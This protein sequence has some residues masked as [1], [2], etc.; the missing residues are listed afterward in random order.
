MTKNA[1]DAARRHG[2]TRAAI[3]VDAN[4]LTEWTANSLRHAM[5]R[6]V[7]VVL[8]L[9]CG[10]P[11]RPKHPFKH[12]FYYLLNIFVMRGPEER[13]VTLESLGLAGI[14]VHDFVAP[15]E[16]AWQRLPASVAEALARHGCEVVIKFGMGL[17]RDPDSAGVRHG[18]LSFHHGD[19]REYRGRPAGFYEI[20]H[21]RT[22]MGLMVQRLSEKL[23]GGRVMAFARSRVVLH[24]YRQTLAASRRNSESLLT[25]A[26][27][28]SVVGHALDIGSHGTN[29]RLP[30]NPR[31][32]AFLC[33]LG[34]RKVRRLFYGAFIEKQWAV[35]L[36]PASSAAL[37]SVAQLAPKDH[38]PSRGYVFFADSFLLPSGDVILEAVRRRDGKG[39]L[40]VVSRQGERRVVSDY[41][42]GHWS[43]PSVLS[44]DGAH[45]LLPEVASWSAPFLQ[46]I[47][48]DGNFLTRHPLIGLEHL[49]LVDPTH[50]RHEGLDYIFAGT[51]GSEADQLRLWVSS[52]GIFGPYVEH[53][54]SPIV[55]NPERARMGGPFHRSVGRLLRLGQNCAGD[56]GNGLS[57]MEITELSPLVYAE[58]EVLVARAVGV[59]GPHTFHCSGGKMTYD[60]YRNGFSPLAGYRRLRA[61][62]Q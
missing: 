42:A 1:D 34:W 28:A 45:Y 33:V 12:A 48:A 37:V 13:R 51:P 55:I 2:K 44:R 52:G 43:Y 61:R 25:K 46:R 10:N 18:V 39:E 9:R 53:P 17:L 30:G 8:V 27:H 15:I 14:P 32:L 57:V 7:E 6:N 62:C 31:V 35:T 4:G 36:A 56:Y 20:L 16:G 50:L 54:M 60:W 22:S 21:R 23:D 49:R 29:Y 38:L 59:L 40:V 47:T 26:V 5:G 58:T 41:A 24:S 11:H 3:L 19:P